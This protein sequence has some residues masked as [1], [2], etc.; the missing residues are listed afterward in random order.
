MTAGDSASSRT[1]LMTR[2]RV[3]LAFVVGAI[4]ALLVVGISHS[5]G[6]RVLLRTIELKKSPDLLEGC[7][8]GTDDIDREAALRY[9]RSVA[10]RE[11]LLR[12]VATLLL[13]LP[14]VRA[15]RRALRAESGEIFFVVVDSTCIEGLVFDASVLQYP[16]PHGGQRHV[17][18]H[19]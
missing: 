11:E 4:A 2:R 1:K 17:G 13:E 3:A 7:L 18:C 9:V 15:A 5:R 16:H 19:V 10:G 14:S 12:L 6:I 8:F